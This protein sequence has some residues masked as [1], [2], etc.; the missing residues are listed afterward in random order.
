MSEFAE[1][2]PNRRRPLD[3]AATNGP[4]IRRAGVADLPGAA[5]IIAVREG[6]EPEG[7]LE[8]LKLELADDRDPPRSVVWVAAI[9]DRV[10]GF[11]R[12]GY[13][14][15]P[16][17]SPEDVAPEGWYLLGLI[18]DPEFRRR[19]LGLLL[20]RARLEWIAE[21]GRK[22]YYFAS[23]RNLVT[24][25]LHQRLGFREITRAFSFPGASFTGGVGVLCVLDV[26]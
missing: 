9:G 23:A 6:R 20:T 7:E 10:V 3:P 2:A 19:G 12:A 16:P 11:A 18:V 4:D 24:L 21:R 8:R 14:A 22:A 15:P 1:Y 5:R 17:E 26:G 25:S 13:F